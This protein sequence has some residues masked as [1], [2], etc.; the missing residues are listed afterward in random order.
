MRL[1]RRHRDVLVGVAIL[2]GALVLALLWVWAA[3]HVLRTP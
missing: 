1:P 2:A 3:G